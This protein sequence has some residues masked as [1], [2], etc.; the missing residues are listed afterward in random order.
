MR[1][2]FFFI[3]FL[4]IFIGSGLTNS[5][6]GSLTPSANP[7]CNGT[8]ITITA[9]TALAGAGETWNSSLG[10]APITLGSYGTITFY[11]TSAGTATITY[12]APSGSP[13]I[14]LVVTID[15]T[16]NAGIISGLNNICQ[17][18]TTTLMAVGGAMSPGGWNSSNPTVVNFV[19]VSTS[20]SV[21]VLGIS[22]GTSDITYGVNNSCGSNTSPVFTMTVNPTP[23]PPFVGGPNNVCQNASITL[24]GTPSGGNWSCDAGLG[25]VANVF[26]GINY[27]ANNVTYTVSSGSCT[28]STIFPVSVNPVPHPGTVSP[29]GPTNNY[30][31]CYAPMPYLFNLTGSSGGGPASGPFSGTIAAWST[32]WVS[33]N[34]SLGYFTTTPVMGAP[35]FMYKL[36]AGPS[37]TIGTTYNITATETNQFGCSASTTQLI[38]YDGPVSTVGL[39]AT[40]VCAGSTITL[41]PTS[42]G[43][44]YVFTPT[45]LA[46]ATG[47]V[48]TGLT[49][50][51]G[52]YTYSFTNSCNTYTFTY[53]FTV[54]PDPAPITGTFSICGGTSTTLSDATPSGTWA[55]DAWWTA[56]IDAGT[57]VVTGGVIAGTA[58]ITYT[59]PV[60]SC[61]VTAV[62]TVIAPPAAPGPITGG[63]AVCVGGGTT[64]LSCSGGGAWSCDPTGIA[65]IDAI[66]GVVT[67]GTAAGTTTVYY[68]VTGTGGCAS[69]SSATLTVNALPVLPA[70]SPTTG[71]CTGSSITLLETPPSTGTWAWSGGGSYATIDA[72]S[73]VMTGITP[74]PTTI[75]YSFT[76]ATTGCSNSTSTSET[77]SLTPTVGAITGPGLVCIGGTLAIANPGPTGGAWSTSDPAI[78][79][80]DAFGNAYGVSAGSCLVSYT[81]TSGSCSATAT[82]PLYVGTTAVL[83]TAWGSVFYGPYSP[84]YTY[85]ICQSSGG[86][87]TLEGM[88]PG[89][90]Y[91]VVSGAAFATVTSGG[92]VMPNTSAPLGTTA[93]VGIQYSMSTLC[94]PAY[95][96]IVWVTID[97]SSILPSISGLPVAGHGTMSNYS[98]NPVA[99]GT[100][101]PYYSGISL[102]SDATTSYSE[103]M[104]MTYP[105]LREVTFPT[106]GTYVIYNAT[107]N[108]ACGAFPMPPFHITLY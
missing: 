48:I 34:T 56:S 28:N 47:D 99:T 54:Y 85:E 51:T 25:N 69:S 106:T 80:I 11:G 32:T 68:T 93:T 24:T 78:G 26:T 23:T 35:G 17:T 107:Y 52:T 12:T 79:T 5:Y 63:L 91:T 14:T 103:T 100:S 94:G 104:F 29:I 37:A 77:V 92:A 66:T 60:H 64:T 13:V 65:S 38:T 20:T 49:P 102:S 108:N 42:D 15:P 76:D 83:T 86:S 57:G 75:T 33:S 87:F 97:G 73:G 1:K 39:S 10:V 31:W 44:T 45:T 53:A 30:H 84:S 72:T 95:S 88:P 4:I 43:V 70:I 2:N 27:G 90:T 8:S 36:H 81:V 67:P 98:F 50:G 6:A 19:P 7:F 58:N 89:G 9:P 41:A 101:Y 96:N 22:P 16:P 18:T 61:S 105:W 82:F 62:E 40:G 71:V 21:T 74:G 55:S 46:S 59:E 3:V